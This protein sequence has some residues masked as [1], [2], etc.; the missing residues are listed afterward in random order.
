MLETKLPHGW[1]LFGWLVMHV[2]VISEPLAEASDDTRNC[3]LDVTYVLD[4]E[5][6]SMNMFNRKKRTTLELETNIIGHIVGRDRLG[7][8]LF[9]FLL[10]PNYCRMITSNLLKITLDQ[11][12][13]F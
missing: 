11:H 13:L 1:N 5:I 4:T 12:L 2:A 7:E 8:V 6:F 3:S 9:F 10:L